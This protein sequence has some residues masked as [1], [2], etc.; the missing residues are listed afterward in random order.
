MILESVLLILFVSCV[1]KAGTQGLP[2]TGIDGTFLLPADGC[3]LGV[4]VRNT[5]CKCVNSTGHI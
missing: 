5:D 3:K 4:V 1:L 2:C